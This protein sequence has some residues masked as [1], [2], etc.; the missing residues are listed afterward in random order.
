M[1]EVPICYEKVNLLLL[2]VNWKVWIPFSSY[3]GADSD[4]L[5]SYQS[6]HL[7]NC[8]EYVILKKLFFN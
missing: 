3:V 8:S 5:L 4:N 6:L 2:P 7:R 1:A